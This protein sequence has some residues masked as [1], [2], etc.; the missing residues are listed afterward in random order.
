MTKKHILVL[1]DPHGIPGVPDKTRRCDIIHQI[2]GELERRYSLERYVSIGDVPDILKK[3]PDLVLLDL[4]EFSD[5][6]S[7]K[8]LD[9][10]RRI[11]NEKP[12]VPIVVEYDPP[13]FDRSWEIERKRKSEE[14]K[15]RLRGVGAIVTGWENSILN[16][17]IRTL[18][19][20]S[21]LPL[22]GRSIIDKNYLG[23]PVILGIPNNSIISACP[24]NNFLAHG[25]IVSCLDTG[26]M[27]FCYD[28]HFLVYWNNKF[29][30]N[31]LQ[32]IT[33]QE[34]TERIVLCTKSRHTHTED[35]LRDG[36]RIHGEIG[37]I[38]L[39]SGD[40]FTDQIR[41]QLILDALRYV[42][43]P[44]KPYS[45]VQFRAFKD[46][47]REFMKDKDKAEKQIEKL[48][49]ELDTNAL[50]ALQYPKN[51]GLSCR[52]EKTKARIKYLWDHE[53]G[54]YRIERD[55]SERFVFSYLVGD[56]DCLTL[57]GYTPTPISSQYVYFGWIRRNPIDNPEKV[58]PYLSH[59]R[60]VSLYYLNRDMREK[61]SEHELH[62]VDDEFERRVKLETEGRR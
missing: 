30:A 28:D 36:I 61:A 37:E 33:D 58:G 15:I 11:R 26:Y 7:D 38:D 17:V 27:N 8:K 16:T 54:L 24:K 9:L 46:L 50:S 48:A 56:S 20:V 53:I 55:G 31:G 18:D 52:L 62:I 6:D 42:Q 47:F 45:K 1:E 44:I 39:Y 51:S 22:K 12:N 5:Q 35:F 2:A 32:D 10:L 41:G 19:G 40:S 49:S 59:G 3:D 4:D 25:V 23:K 21:A 29:G 34:F 14:K 60:D 13:L 57:M 43:Q